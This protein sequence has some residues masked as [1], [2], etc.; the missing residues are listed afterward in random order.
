MDRSTRFAVGL[1]VFLALLA[2]LAWGWRD[3]GGG[4]DPGVKAC[5]LGG[6]LAL[7]V[8][9]GVQTATEAATLDDLDEVAALAVDAGDEDLRL[10][11]GFA[12]AMVESARVHPDQAEEAVAP[13]VNRLA[14]VCAS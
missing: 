6:E 1:V 9:A 14:E 8:D 5:R 11:G 2:V 3:T 4:E 7:R 10:A 13:A 12:Q